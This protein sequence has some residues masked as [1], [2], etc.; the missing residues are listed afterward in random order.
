MLPVTLREPSTWPAGFVP[1]MVDTLR[2]GSEL[3][4]DIHIQRASKIVYL[5]DRGVVFSPRETDMLEANGID[6]LLGRRGRRH[7]LSAR[8]GWRQHSP[9]LGRIVS[10][11]DAFDA[12][13][14]KARIQRRHPRL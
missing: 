7:R 5:R 4:F 9:I 2:R 3:D 8:V 1:V 11:T 12:L 13:T 10:I 6:T 14:T